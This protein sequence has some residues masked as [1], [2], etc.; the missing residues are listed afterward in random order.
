[1]SLGT[2]LGKIVGGASAPAVSE[3]GNIVERYAPGLEG[4]DKIAK[5]IL[6]RVTAGQD[7]ARASDVPMASGLRWADAL[8]NGINRLIRP[9]VTILLLGPWFGWIHEPSM[10]TMRPENAEFVRLILTFWF[11]GRFL[12]KDI[13]Q[14]L[15][16]LKGL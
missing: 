11:G 8:V 13:P 15:K 10:D 6:D 1:M 14:A 3:I 12:T 7:A 16:Y 5:E 2:F 4:K 9:A